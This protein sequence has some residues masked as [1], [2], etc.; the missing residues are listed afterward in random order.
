MDLLILRGI[1][2]AARILSFFSPV[3][4]ENLVILN[5]YVLTFETLQ[6]TIF[7]FDWAKQKVFLRIDTLFSH[8]PSS[9]L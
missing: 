3:K 4:L 7:N 9:Y 1:I 2:D 8:Y 5:S 6:R